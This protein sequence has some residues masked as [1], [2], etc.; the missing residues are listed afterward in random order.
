MTPATT[1]DLLPL[2]EDGF[3]RALDRISP[4]LL[5][6]ARCF[7]TDDATADRMVEGAWS[8]ALRGEVLGAALPVA[9]A[10]RMAVPAA[11]DPP[12]LVTARRLLRT[13]LA[14][15]GARLPG[16]RDRRS[17]AAGP[18]ARAPLAEGISTLPL[19]VRVVLVLHDVHGWPAGDVQALLGVSPDV[20]ARMLGHARSGLV[21]LAV[22]EPV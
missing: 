5:G 2:D 8:S 20:G 6:L 3:V 11:D 9:L 14:P 22:G 4:A 7:V 1:D 19:A 10:R 21:P 12:A 16:Q 17:G 15:G 13:V 18:A